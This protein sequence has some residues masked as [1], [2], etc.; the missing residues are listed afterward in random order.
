MWH[1]TIPGPDNTDANKRLGMILKCLG[2][3]G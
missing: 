2:A 1:I 3:T